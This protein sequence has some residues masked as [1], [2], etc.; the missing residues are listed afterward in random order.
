MLKQLYNRYH[1]KGLNVVGVAVW[2]EP[3]N[4]IEAIKE[5]ELPWHCIL[6]AQTIPTDL[7][8]I[9]GIT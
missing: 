6:N 5:H 7:Y 9:Q 8:G 4:T 3:Q 1:D 2:D